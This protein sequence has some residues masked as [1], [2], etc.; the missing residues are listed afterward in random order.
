MCVHGMGA[1]NC[2]ELTSRGGIVQVSE[3]ELSFSHV[4]DDRRGSTREEVTCA[5]ADPA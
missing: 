5:F 4:H 3:A 2:A 1:T